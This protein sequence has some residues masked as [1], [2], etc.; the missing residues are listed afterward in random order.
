MRTAFLSLT[1][2][3][4]TLLDDNDDDDD[5]EKAQDWERSGSDLSTFIR[6]LVQA[7]LSR[8]ITGMEMK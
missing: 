2:A 6:L 3:R 1:Q 8:R 5:N 7:L 4:M